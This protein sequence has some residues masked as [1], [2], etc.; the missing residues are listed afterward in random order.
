MISQTLREARKY[1][2]A[3]GKQIG[4]KNRPAF[5]LSARVG[6]MN[7][8]NGF[9]YYKGQYHMFYQYHP[10]D[11][12]WGPMHW[13]H[14]VSGDLLHWE[15]LP[16]ALAPDEFYDRDGCFSGSAIT[17]PDERQLLMYTGVV[18]ERQRDGGFCEIQTQCLAVGDG[19]DY[20]KYEK[21][22]VLDIKDLPEG[23]SRYDFR[24]PK[25]WRK[26]DGTYY[27]VAG[28]RPADGSGQILLFASQDGFSW[29]YKKTLAANNNRFGKMW[30]CPDFFRLDGKWVLLT[31]PQDM[32]PSGFEYH[33]GNGTLCLIGEFDEE[34]ESFTEQH[35]QSIDYGIDFYAPQTV[36]APDGRRIMIGW[37]QNWDTCNFRTQNTP[38]FG[39]MSLP[40]ELSIQNGRLYQQPIR[41]LEEMRRNR[42]AYENIFFSD[43]IKLEGIKGRRVDMELTLRPGD[44]EIIYQKFAVRFA[45]NKDYQTSLSFRPRESI[46]KVD[47]KFSGS[48][49]AI[50]HQRRSRVNSRNGELKLRII[51]D[52]FSV[53]VFINDGEQVMTAIIYTCQEADGISFF[54]DGVVRMDVVKYDLL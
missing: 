19:I 18:R 35:N 26:D 4:E 12:H 42:V 30:E 1:E 41:E 2:E 46:L 37:M 54:A 40:R 8:P 52:R 25:V 21:N 6:W 22:P 39:Q 53:E 47:R 38:W 16:A 27:C 10:Y 44:T 36:L 15:Y 28:N 43:V 13:G 20:E 48:R 3:S 51:L 11:A 17:L 23:A 49:R 34:T 14:A 31:S 29:H 32:L 33:N 7:D 24:D 50:I 45:Q 5:H 9:S